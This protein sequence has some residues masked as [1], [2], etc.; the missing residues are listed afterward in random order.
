MADCEPPNDFAKFMFQTSTE[1]SPEELVFHLDHPAFRSG[2]LE[3]MQLAYAKKLVCGEH[4]LLVDQASNVSC[5]MKLL[6]VDKHQKLA[7]VGLQASAWVHSQSISE[8]TVPLSWLY[9]GSPIVIEVGS[10]PV[11]LL[12]REVAFMWPGR[13]QHV[14]IK[15]G[16]EVLGDD[17]GLGSILLGL[18]KGQE[19]SVNIDGEE[20]PIKVD[21]KALALASQSN[22]HIKW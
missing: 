13:C 4:V 8:R 20:Y 14:Y 5:K 16:V 3:D 19:F 9:G 17:T 11:R 22:R 15:R 2:S 1:K 10:F 6:S 12:R 21:I 18:T 7:T